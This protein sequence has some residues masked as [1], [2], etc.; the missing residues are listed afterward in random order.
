MGS[1][2]EPASENVAV[3]DGKGGCP[4]RLRQFS[5]VTQQA[6]G[7]VGVISPPVS[8]A[9]VVTELLKSLSQIL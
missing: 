6:S 3:A 5:K 7:R 4:E 8:P 2:V 1:G 9:W